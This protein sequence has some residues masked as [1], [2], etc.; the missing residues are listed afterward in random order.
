M[1]GHSNQN[2]LKAAGQI[3]MTYERAGVGPTRDG[4]NGG[5]D[6]CFTDGRILVG[7]LILRSAEKAVAP[8]TPDG[9]HS[10][11]H[12]R[13]LW[14]YHPCRR[15]PRRRRGLSRRPAARPQGGAIEMKAVIHNAGTS[16]KTTSSLWP[17]W[18]G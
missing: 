3:S 6:P 7:G 14:R 13:D 17:V 18:L 12:S 11:S 5:G 4:R 8:D 16:T 15:P 1:N 2:L 10:P 9:H